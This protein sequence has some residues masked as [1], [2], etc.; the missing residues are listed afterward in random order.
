MIIKFIDV[1]DFNK[2][3]ISLG[4]S[5][6]SFAKEVG[7]SVPH[8]NQIINGNRN[9][10]PKIAKKICDGMGTGFDEIFFVNSDNKSYQAKTIA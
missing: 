8:F 4:H 6:R 9:P 1:G 10:S 3:L 7:V 2:R 5:Q